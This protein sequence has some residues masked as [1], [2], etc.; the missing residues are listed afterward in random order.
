MAAYPSYGI[1]LESSQDLE[2]S[3]RDSVSE[4]GT[5][6]S[7]QMRSTNYY[8]FVLNHNL[9]VAQYN[10]LMTTYAAGPRDVYTL[11]YRNESPVVTYSVKFTAPP[12]ITKNHGGGRYTVR[13]ALRGTQD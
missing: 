11:T 2:P 13:V 4:S 6:H 5:L 9:T 7:R 3:W 12:Q 10:A 1:L 8:R